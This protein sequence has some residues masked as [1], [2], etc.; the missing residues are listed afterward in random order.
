MS[1]ES[2]SNWFKTYTVVHTVYEV[3]ELLYASL[4]GVAF[5]VDPVCAFIQHFPQFAALESVTTLFIKLLAWIHC[6]LLFLLLLWVTR[7]VNYI[8]ITRE[9]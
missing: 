5:A 7:I 8:G 3:K 4:C 2:K 9:D 6:I 1:N